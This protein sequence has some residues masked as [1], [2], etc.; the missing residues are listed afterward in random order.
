MAV[1]STSLYSSR[2][3]K[4]NFPILSTLS[5]STTELVPKRKIVDILNEFKWKNNSRGTDE[6]PAVLL[7]EY[8]L[9]YSMW[10][11]NFAR[12]IQGAFDLSTN[13]TIDPYLALYFV[14]NKN[15]TGFNY[16]LPYLLDNGA[17]M[18]NIR[19]EWAVFDKNL[20]SAAANALGGDSKS[21]GTLGDLGKIVGFGVGTAAGFA[22]PGI[23]AEDVYEYKNTALEEITITF[24]LYNTGTTKE[25]LDNYAFVNLITFQNLKT[26]TSFL[27][28]IPPKLYS[29]SM[30]N[31]CQ[32]GL[33][34]PVAVITD[35]SIESIGTVRELRELNNTPLLIPEAYK[36]SITLR[37]LLPNSSNIFEGAIGGRKVEVLTEFAFNN[38]VNDIIGGAT[39]SI[40]E[41]INNFRPTPTGGA[42]LATGGANQ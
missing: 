10:A 42:T 35:L 27:T 28:Y 24:P 41:G 33:Y 17:K 40:G 14:K 29:V 37:Q 26:R 12:V 32:G 11:S 31:N 20:M 30:N 5:S 1:P 7:K 38:T 2:P 23:G 36:V 22:S 9:A 19:N 18:R 8:E 6:V 4:F 16:N 25:A 39:S 13:G 34:W 15:G 21:G 3:R